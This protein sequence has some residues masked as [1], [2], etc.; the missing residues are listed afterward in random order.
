[1][2][3]IADALAAAYRDETWHWMPHSVSGPFDV[4]AGA[5]LVQHTTWASAERALDALRDAGALDPAA[6][7]A[8]PEA[9]IA[10]LVRVCGTPAIKA[11]R[12]RA[13]AETI[14]RHGGLDALLAL[15]QYDLRDALLATHGI[16]PETADAIALYAAG[17]PAFIIDAYT[18]RLFR[19]LGLGP[20][21]NTYHAWQRWFVEALPPDVRR[22]RD[23]HAHIVLHA[24]ALCRATPR[25]ASCPLL[26]HCPEGRLATRAARA[27]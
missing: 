3:Q 1:V 27:S 26:S 4:I 22:Y 10:G 17:K 9:Q 2:R 15:P 7:L 12:L 11:R 19:R 23:L 16:G 18:T 6:L 20:D 8:M 13:I 5:V 21:A 24:K 25:C 14:V